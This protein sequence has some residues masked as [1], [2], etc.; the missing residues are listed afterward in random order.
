MEDDE[1]AIKKLAHYSIRTSDMEASRRFYVEIIGLRVGTRPP[2]PFPG[3][4]LYLGE[5]ETDNGAVHIIGVDPSDPEGLLRYL[6]DRPGSDTRGTG[7]LDHIAFLATG[8]LDLRD[9]LGAHG[10]SYYERTVPALGQ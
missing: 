10:I 9:R 5:D 6:G 1:M 4:W 8:W 2:F 3:L 7:A